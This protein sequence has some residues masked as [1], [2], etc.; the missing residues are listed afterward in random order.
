MNAQQVSGIRAG[1]KLPV[2][3]AVLIEKQADSRARG[4]DSQ[5]SGAIVGHYPV[6]DAERRLPLL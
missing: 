4:A 3:W 5:C 2:V 1:C 6:V